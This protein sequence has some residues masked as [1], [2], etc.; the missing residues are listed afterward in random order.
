VA[1]VDELRAARHRRARPA[2][3]RAPG[4]RLDVGGLDVATAYELRA[5]SSLDVATVDELR[6]ARHRRARPALSSEASASTSP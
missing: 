5:A 2:P 3:R 4:Q 6:A 1:T